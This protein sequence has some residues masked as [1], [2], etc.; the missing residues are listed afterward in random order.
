MR[1]RI[2]VL[3]SGRGSNLQA[4]LDYLDR[5]SSHASYE[6]A[7]VISN[8]ADAPALDLARSH[9]ISARFIDADASGA[10]LFATLAE[11]RID[12]VA[13]AGYL[14][15]I[16]A[17]VVAEYS[18]RMLNIH[19]ALLPAHGGAGMY[20]ARIH[21]AV[22]AA[23]DRETGATVHLVNDEYDRGPIVAQWRIPVLAGDDAHSLALRV[24]KVE[25]ILYPRAIDIVAALHQLNANE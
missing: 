2:A 19:P 7:V 10:T 8:R 13:L 18:G 6:V 12:I 20:G 23:G 4:I 1:A 24:L 15:R 16:P 11:H 14:K 22:I 17:S 25:H 21:E 5:A 9:G 3:A